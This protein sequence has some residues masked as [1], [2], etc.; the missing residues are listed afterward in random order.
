MQWLDFKKQ[1]LAIR[2]KALEEAKRHNKNP[3]EFT[4]SAADF[5]ILEEVATKAERHIE[6]QEVVYILH[7]KKWRQEVP[8]QAP[9]GG[10]NLAGEESFYYDT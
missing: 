8:A 5:M 4:L 7:G 6:G 10:I 1:W 9:K 3:A 2:L